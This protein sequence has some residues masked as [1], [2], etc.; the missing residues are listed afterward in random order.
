M[1]GSLRERAESLLRGESPQRPRL[2]VA[3]APPRAARKMRAA[4]GLPERVGLLVRAVEGGSPAERAGIQRGDLLAA[5]GGRDL[6][7]VD[8]LH[9]ALDAA[10]DALALTVVRGTEDLEVE[11]KLAEAA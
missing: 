7:S 6:D 10:R 1:S 9:E 3:V 11:V 8:A 5:A 2:G 4:V